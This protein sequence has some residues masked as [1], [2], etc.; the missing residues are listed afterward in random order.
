MAGV[1]T[2]KYGHVISQMAD[3]VGV[4]KSPV[5]RETIEAAERVLEERLERLLDGW[6]LRVIFLD[7]IRA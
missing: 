5:S 2:R 3:T 6:D 7:G 4:S 1:S